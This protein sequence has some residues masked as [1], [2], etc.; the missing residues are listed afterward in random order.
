[1]PREGRRIAV[2][3]DNSEHTEQAL[4]WYIA[5]VY[6]TSDVLVLIHIATPL[7]REPPQEELARARSSPS[8]SRKR[9]A[10]CRSARPCLKTSWQVLEKLKAVC[11][12]YRV[13]YISALAHGEVET[14]F[15]D[16]AAA[17]DSDVVLVWSRCARG[18][19]LQRARA[20]LDPTTS[21]TSCT[22]HRLRCPVIMYR[23]GERESQRDV[24]PQSAP[25]LRARP[26]SVSA[27]PSASSKLRQKVGSGTRGARAASSSPA[28]RDEAS[29]RRRP[30]RERGGEREREGEREGEGVPVCMRVRCVCAG[31]CVRMGTS[32]AYMS[33]RICVWVRCTSV[34]HSLW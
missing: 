11:E 27:S 3:C 32:Y 19:V 7:D 5:E 31:A 8:P 1:M 16:V 12:E 30:G 26:R 34:C 14:C 18:S 9:P 33:T 17:H 21:V 28:P 23:R 15:A 2:A 24:R 13:S 10:D 25:H 29:G 6:R 4:R 22:L 20:S